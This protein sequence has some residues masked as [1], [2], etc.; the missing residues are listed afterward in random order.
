V[1]AAVERGDRERGVR[2]EVVREDDGVE[3]GI[4]E[5][6]VVQVAA[7]A[8]ACDFGWDEAA[9]AD[10]LEPDRAGQPRELGAARAFPRRRCARPWRHSTAPLESGADLFSR[11]ACGSARR[12]RRAAA[13]R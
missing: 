13:D 9:D 6:V 11:R 2:V 10:R 12:T 1:H 5:G 4:E 3:P 8:E 7:R